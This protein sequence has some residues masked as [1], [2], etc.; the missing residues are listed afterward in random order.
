MNCRAKNQ[1]LFWYFLLKISY[2]QYFELFRKIEF[3]D[4][5]WWFRTVCSM[6]K[7]H[8]TFKYFKLSVSQVNLPLSGHLCTLSFLVTPD[9]IDEWLQKDLKIQRE[10]FL[11]K[12]L[13]LYLVCIV[14]WIGCVQLAHRCT[15]SCTGWSPP[16][17][18][19]IE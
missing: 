15:F 16:K 13:K 6:K 9:P 2:L 11:K 14:A 1:W 4:K 12:M 18:K 5:N 3:W 19:K 8:A 10:F 17:M 7:S